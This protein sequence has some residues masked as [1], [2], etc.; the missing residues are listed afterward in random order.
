M[1]IIKPDEDLAAKCIQSWWRL[2]QVK[3]R[4][5]ILA[6][7]VNEWWFSPDCFPATRVRRLAFESRIN[8]APG[9]NMSMF[10]FD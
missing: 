3:R 1:S 2:E 4:L 10:N 9:N 5:R 6:G 7:E 8:S